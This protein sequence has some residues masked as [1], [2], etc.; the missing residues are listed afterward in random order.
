MKEI[1]VVGIMFY[2]LKKKK[3]GN[4]G[5]NIVVFILYVFEIIYN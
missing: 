2:V 1:L 3:K 4:F 5:I